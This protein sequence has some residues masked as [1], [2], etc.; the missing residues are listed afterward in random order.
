MNAGYSAGLFYRCIKYRR[1]IGFKFINFYSFPYLH[2]RRFL[3]TGIALLL[4]L[5]LPANVIRIKS[6]AA[7]HLSAKTRFLA[8]SPFCFL[9]AK[10]NSHPSFGCDP[11]ESEDRELQTGGNM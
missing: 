4:E 11:S 7:T 6:Q 10:W 1:F 8:T 9:R 2:L 5:I 3:L